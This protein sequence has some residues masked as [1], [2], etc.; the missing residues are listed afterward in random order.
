MNTKALRAHACLLLLAASLISDASAEATPWPPMKTART[1]ISVAV[2]E[3]SVLVAGGI[4]FFRTTNSCERLV[5]GEKHWRP[6]PDLPRRLHHVALAGYGGRAYAAGGY[7]NLGFKHD[8]KPALWSLGDGDTAWR[9]E[10]ELPEAIG[11]HALMPRDGFLYLLGG[12]SL[13]GDSAAVRRYEIA[14]G[15]WQSMAPMPV[16]LNSFATV[17]FEGDLLVI[18]GRSNTLGSGIALMS[19]YSVAEDRWISEAPLP[20]GR[21]GHSA[22]VVG[23]VLHVFGG[24]LFNPEILIDRHDSWS[25]DTGWRKPITLAKPRHGTAAFA[26]EGDVIVLGGATRPAYGSI[27][28]MTGLLEAFSV[29]E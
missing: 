6:C 17:W 27:F 9:L 29:A 11:E 22:A 28:S 19:R 12:R 15:E 2:L 3:D 10:A 20:V 24:E 25:P 4:A 23:G 16:A 1:E 26:R 13:R 8:K 18:G 5:F 14:T 7:V 21:G